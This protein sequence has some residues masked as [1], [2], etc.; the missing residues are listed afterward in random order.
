V[1]GGNRCLELVRADAPVRQR[2][3]DDRQATLDQAAMP[4]RPVLIGQGN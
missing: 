3:P 4:E 2:F 1:H